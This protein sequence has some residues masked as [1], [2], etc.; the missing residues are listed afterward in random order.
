MVVYRLW[1]RGYRRRIALFCGVRYRWVP[2]WY[3]T[4]RSGGDVGCSFEDT[5]ENVKHTSIGVL[6]NGP[7]GVS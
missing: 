7:V 1:N 2:R 4:C 3:Q 5:S 6:N